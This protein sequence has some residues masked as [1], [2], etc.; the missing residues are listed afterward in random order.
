MR[1]WW[2]LLCT[3]STNFKSWWCLLCTRSTNFK[4]WWCPLCTR[5]TNFKSWWCPLCTRPTNFKSWWC[6]LCTRSTNFKLDFYN[7]TSLQVNICS[8]LSHLPS[9]LN[10]ERTGV[11]TRWERWIETI[12]YIHSILCLHQPQICLYPLKRQIYHGNIS[13]DYEVFIVPS[14]PDPKGRKVRWVTCIDITLHP[15][16]S[17]IFNI[18][19]SFSKNSEPI[20]TKLCRNV[21]S[22]LF[23]DIMRKNVI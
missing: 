3:R 15:S 7:E 21:H 20:E 6:P 17:V 1:S 12:E 16:T 18:S 5:S 10:T 19:T 22:Y 13:L 23:F 9:Y 14:S 2:C 8:D 4:S 11:L